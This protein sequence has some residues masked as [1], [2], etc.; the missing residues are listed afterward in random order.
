MEILVSAG[1]FLDYLNPLKYV[2]QDQYLS[3]WQLLFAGLLQG[4]WARLIAWSCMVFAFYFG[5]IRQNVGFA[6]VLFG[7]AIFITYCGAI[8][9]W[10]F[11]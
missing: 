7:G 9:G 6:I 11:A 3:I 2:S 10:L 4:F 8:V 5:V 1:G